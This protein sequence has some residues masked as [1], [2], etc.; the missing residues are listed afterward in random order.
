MS[1]YLPKNGDAL[2]EGASTWLT[3][4]GPRRTGMG[5]ERKGCLKADGDHGQLVV[6][7]QPLRS[8]SLGVEDANHTIYFC[9]LPRVT[10]RVNPGAMRGY[11]M[12]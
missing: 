3:L 11:V 12:P 7:V 9:E 6:R 1:K 2:F 5:E 10:V 4:F 8:P